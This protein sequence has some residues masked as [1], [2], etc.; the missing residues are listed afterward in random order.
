MFL[1]TI[2]KIS[3]EVASG[4][5]F[6]QGEPG[7]IVES[8]PTRILSEFP[9]QDSGLAG[10]KDGRYD[11][12]EGIH[13]MDDL[14][15]LCKVPSVIERDALLATLH[16]RGIEA[17]S[18]ERD[19]IVNLAG[20]PNLALGGYSAVFEGYPVFVPRESEG[21]GREALAV[22]R[23]RDL[24]AISDGH[25]DRDGIDDAGRR[26]LLCSF[27]SIALPVALNLVALYW[28]FRSENL[29]RERPVS[30][31]GA[32]AINGVILIGAVVAIRSHFS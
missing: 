3:S 11:L 21:A 5:S 15:L 14:V 12:R 16:E 27:W 22:F 18:P 23:R 31:L 19:V 32:V 20:E 6:S 8:G 25:G 2:L 30:A 1:A 13:V 26:F 24:H 29:F 17:L 10:P 28:F 4:E 9:L 7:S